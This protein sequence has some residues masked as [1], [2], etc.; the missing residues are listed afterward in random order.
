[1]RKRIPQITRSDAAWSSGLSI[2]EMAGAGIK[3]PS[4]PTTDT[5]HGCSSGVQ[6][7]DTPISAGP[8]SH[9]RQSPITHTIQIDIRV[10]ALARQHAAITASGIAPPQ[11]IRAALRKAAKSW[12]PQALYVAPMAAER[13]R[14]RA[15]MIRT[16]LAVPEAVF[17]RIQAKQDPLGV[18]SRWSLLRGQLE[19]LV[20]QE[21]DW[22]LK[23]I[24]GVQDP[25][26]G[27]A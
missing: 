18:C 1:M 27:R 7:T 26:D 15:W 13:C 4:A 12:R 5:A 23:R 11:I 8:A 25:H 6:P 16:S 21:I 20:W 14:E 3:P 24:D 19:P 17:D 10:T 9:E 22:L 2:R